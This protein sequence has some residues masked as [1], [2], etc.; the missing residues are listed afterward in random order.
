M[1]DPAARQ[2]SDL[3]IGAATV[4]LLA[5]GQLAL[6]PS[7][8]PLTTALIALVGGWSALSGVRRNRPPRGTGWW[9]GVG[10]VVGFSISDVLY[11]VTVSL[12][13][14]D[15][16][17]RLAWWASSLAFV[18]VAI[19]GFRRVLRT[20]E[21]QVDVEARLDSVIV[22]VALAHVGWYLVVRPQVEILGWRS[23][24]TAWMVVFIMVV[25]SLLGL[26]IARGLR[27][28]GSFAYWCFLAAALLTAGHSLVYHLFE[29]SIAWEVAPIGRLMAGLGYMFGALCT[30]HPSMR[31]L[32]DPEAPQRHGHARLLIVGAGVAVVPVWV[33]LDAMAA[34]SL[35]SVD[36]VGAMLGIVLTAAALARVVATL[37]AR[38]EV[39]QALVDREA[40]FRSL[41][42]H[43]YDYVLVLD[44]RWCVSWGTANT[45]A[46]TGRGVDELV[47][48]VITEEVHP[49]DLGAFIDALEAC[50]VAEGG[51][52][53]GQVRAVDADGEVKWIEFTLVNQLGNPAVGGIVVNYRDATGRM[54]DQREL[55]RQARHDPL[56]GLPNRAQLT[57]TLGRWL[58]E[59]RSLAVLFLDL[60]RFKVVNDSLGH[61]VGDRLLQAVAARLRMVVHD[62]DLVARIGG[63]EFVVVSRGA[64]RNEAVAV[65]ARICDTLDEPIEVDGHELSART[66]IGV[67]VS[68]TDSTP[69][70]LLRDADTAMYRVKHGGRDGF[71][72]FDDRWR[73]ATA[74]RLR[75]EGAIR[76]ALDRDELDVA[77]QPIVSAGTGRIVGVEALLRWRGEPPEG[78]DGPATPEEL[79]G[80]AEETGLIS[81]VGEWMVQRACHDMTGLRSVQPGLDLT[82][83]VNV[84][85]AQLRREGFVVAVM[86]ALQR[87]GLPADRLVLELTES[88]LVEDAPVATGALH[89]LRHAGVRLAMDDFGTGYSALANLTRIPLSVVKI[90]RS[91]VEGLIVD[92][93]Q[94]AI[95]RAIVGMARALGMHIVA[96]GVEH[97]AQAGVLADLGCD[98]MQ[99]YLFGRPMPLE[100]LRARLGL[101]GPPAQVPARSA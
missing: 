41:V 40:R 28:G 39:Q 31:L 70:A 27:D 89:G 11:V 66:S 59:D 25:L 90:D 63:D 93:H 67:A 7:W 92:G 47:G 96:E 37:R 50:T 81:R 49:D 33:L 14:Q 101:P 21:R 26:L 74:A 46:V 19:L 84:S 99:G 16:P 2:R 13:D 100:D 69:A 12:G 64:A 42:E 55:E 53:R 61:H 56:T 80:V 32:S 23:Y 78:V 4:G 86:S 43:A 71:A 68:S 57:E 29:R 10:G 30:W 35:P 62:H 77:Y 73:A 91:F 76:R 24:A 17:L 8:R 75:L 34:I 65:A 38:D 85:G 18:M 72:L 3:P 36:P 48:H 87:S 52:S 79:I 60:D 1:S 9:L 82:V 95:V 5:V 54:A 97:H 6:D 83:S 20:G 88:V 44:A 58:R 51:R 45:G 94:A 22:V 15:D 98:Q